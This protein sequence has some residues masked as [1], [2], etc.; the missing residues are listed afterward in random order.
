MTVCFVFLR[1]QQCS[2]QIA[3]QS[4]TPGLPNRGPQ[5]EVNKLRAKSK[6]GL[7]SLEEKRSVSLSSRSEQFRTNRPAISGNAR[8]GRYLQLRFLLACLFLTKYQTI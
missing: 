8:I 5:A 6:S 2:V 3:L 4:K 7:Y 1:D